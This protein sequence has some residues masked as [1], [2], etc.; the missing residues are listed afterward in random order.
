MRKLPPSKK[1]QRPKRLV[2]NIRISNYQALQRFIGDADSFQ[3]WDRNVSRITNQ[4]RYDIF[5]KE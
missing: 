2:L 3:D 4:H 1:C 5:T